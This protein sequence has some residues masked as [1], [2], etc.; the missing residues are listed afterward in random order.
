MNKDSL[1]CLHNNLLIIITEIDR[2]CKKYDIKYSLHSGSLL[3]AV[4]HQGFIPWDDDMDIAM[5]REDYDRFFKICE[6]ELDPR[7]STLTMEKD[8]NYYYGIGKVL[9]NGTEVRQLHLKKKTG[10]ERLWVDIFPYDYISNSRWKRMYQAVNAQ[11]CIKMLEEKMDGISESARLLKK[12]YFSLLHMMNVFTTAEKTKK[13]LIR[14][15][16]KYDKLKDNEI[17]CICGFGYTRQILPNRFFDDLLDYKFENKL[18]SGFKYADKYLTQIF[19]DYMELP[20]EENRETHNLEII[21]LI[22]E[23]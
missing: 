19:G 20:P 14:I 6:T 17:C 10:T 18:L 22:H 5:L 12:V 3:G 1:I 23:D 8:S 7:F 11:L 2:I 13:R 9:L 4:R 15:M 16:R 21:N